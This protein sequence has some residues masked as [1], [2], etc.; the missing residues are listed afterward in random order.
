MTHPQSPGNAGGDDRSAATELIALDAGR[1]ARM[2]A[3]HGM[4]MLAYILDMAV[5]EAWREAT[6]GDGSADASAAGEGEPNRR[7]PP[8]GPT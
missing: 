3:A 7:P 6:E 5:L 1:S 8:R 2:A 4:A